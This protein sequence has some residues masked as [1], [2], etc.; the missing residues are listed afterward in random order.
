MIRQGPGPAALRTHETFSTRQ[1]TG[2]P[3]SFRPRPSPDRTL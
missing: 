3:V 2:Q 1:S